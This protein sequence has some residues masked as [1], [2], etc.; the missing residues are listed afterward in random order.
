MKAGLVSYKICTRAAAQ[1][2]G[3]AAALTWQT[4]KLGMQK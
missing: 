4:V 2:E 3:L 1:P